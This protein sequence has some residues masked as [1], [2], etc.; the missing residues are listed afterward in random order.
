M[1]DITSGTGFFKHF[2]TIILTTPGG[3]TDTPINL[4][5]TTS[6]GGNY[7]LYVFGVTNAAGTGS[8]AANIDPDTH[9]VLKDIL[10]TAYNPDGLLATGVDSTNIGHG[11]SPNDGSPIGFKLLSV[12]FGQA[13]GGAPDDTPGLVDA[14][15][16]SGTFTDNNLADATEALIIYYWHGTADSS[17]LIWYDGTVS[18]SGDGTADNI[19]WHATDG[20]FRIWPDPSP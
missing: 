1:A 6:G 14:A 16:L 10:D 7:G 2:W 19:T 18:L 9:K 11:A 8:M 12:T 3:S 20:I 13:P 17:P 4:S 5:D 15:N